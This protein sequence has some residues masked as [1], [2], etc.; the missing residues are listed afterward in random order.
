MLRSF[1]LDPTET[2]GSLAL[3]RLLEVCKQVEKREVHEENWDHQKSWEIMK[4][5]SR[6][7]MK[8]EAIASLVNDRWYISDM[9]MALEM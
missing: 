2:G 1:R 7:D 4:I 5:R 9:T 6:E 3:Q 8:W